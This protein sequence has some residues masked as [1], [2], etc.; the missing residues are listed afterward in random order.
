MPNRI[1][2]VEE[3][4]KRVRTG[5]QNGVDAD[6]QKQI[7]EML[8]RIDELERALQP[9]A[10]IAALNAKFPKELVEVYL[11]DCNRAW[12]MLDSKQSLAPK[13]EEPFGLP[14]E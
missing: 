10:R 9:F 12:A 6:S 4:I 1:R 13:P 14:A 5:Y 8:A 2:Q 11:H 3:V 7:P